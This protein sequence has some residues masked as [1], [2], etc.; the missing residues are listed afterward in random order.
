MVR[1]L[2]VLVL[3][4]RVS[5]ASAGELAMSMYI[6]PREMKSGSWPVFVVTFTNT[7]NRSIHVLDSAR[8]DLQAAY[9]PIDIYEN[10]RKV[11]LARAISDPG[12]LSDKAYRAIGPHQSAVVRLQSLP[13]AV[14]HLKPGR[15]TARV[16]YREPGRSA[17]IVAVGAEAPLGVRECER[18]GT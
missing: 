17:G 14:H 4:L 18:P 5:L 13:I 10:S 7:S 1:T 8:G 2:I 9:L 15:Y 16:E 11:D 12:P 3:L 6:E